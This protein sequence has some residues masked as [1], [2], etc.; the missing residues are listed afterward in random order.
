[1]TLRRPNLLGLVLL[2]AAPGAASAQATGPLAQVPLPADLLAPQSAT[3]V[4]LRVSFLEGPAFD[5]AGNLF[6]SD[7]IGNRILKLSPEGTVSVFR[8]DS[9]RTNG[10]TFDARGRLISCEGAEQ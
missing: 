10:N 6:F 4:A 1:M 2:A 3:T 8:A 7:I 9:G 5:R